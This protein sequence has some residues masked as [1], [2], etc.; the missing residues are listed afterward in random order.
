MANPI[1]ENPNH[2]FLDQPDLCH[3]MESETHIEPIFYIL[4]LTIVLEDNFMSRFSIYFATSFHIISPFPVSHP[5]QVVQ[6][7]I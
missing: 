2:W 1:M 7:L 3:A 5:N 4:C 6:S